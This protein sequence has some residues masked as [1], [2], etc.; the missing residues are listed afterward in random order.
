MMLRKHS[1]N[2]GI[3]PLRAIFPSRKFPVPEPFGS[4]CT[5]SGALAEDPRDQSVVDLSMGFGMTPNGVE[6]STR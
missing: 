2:L 5:D 6:W 4:V 3:V 1:R